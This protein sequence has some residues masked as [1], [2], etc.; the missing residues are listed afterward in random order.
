[1]EIGKAKSILKEIRM[2]L[3][4]VVLIMVAYAMVRVVFIHI[5]S[6]HITKVVDCEAVDGTEYYE[7]VVELS[8]GERYAYFDDEYKDVGTVIVATFGDDSDSHNS[9]IIDIEQ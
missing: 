3:G 2:V 8:N 7:V 4:L 6:K 1:M 9:S 5:G